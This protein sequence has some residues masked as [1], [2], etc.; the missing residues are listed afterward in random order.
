MRP[1]PALLCG[2]LGCLAPQFPAEFRCAVD[3]DCVGGFYC[4]Q[5][6][7][8]CR[9]GRAAPPQDATPLDAGD[10]SPPLDAGDAAPPLDAG[11]AAPLLDAGD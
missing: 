10:V 8:V 9:R 1:W 4:A 3:E 11:D 6:D 7:G 5:P 2:L